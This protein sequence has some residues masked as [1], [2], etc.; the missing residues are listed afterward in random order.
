M[1]KQKAFTTDI[2]GTSREPTINP[3]WK[4]HFERLTDLRS[5]LVFL[6]A[7]LTD[8]ARQEQQTFS[9]HM[10]DAG[11]DQYDQDFALS[12]ISSEQSALYEIDQALNRICT[13]TYGV[14]ELTGKEIEK[15]RLEAI[16]WT[17]FSLEAQKELEGRGAVTRTKLADRG[18]L[19]SGSSESDGEADEEEGDAP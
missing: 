14:C 6:K 11:T 4:S 1:Q 5:K 2:L 12:M 9:L 15:E 7:G 18:S 13:G 17:R 8:T 10:A 16:L 19:T 3:K